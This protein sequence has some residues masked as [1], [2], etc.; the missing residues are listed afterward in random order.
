MANPVHNFG[1][2]A[3]PGRRS[4]PG[5]GVVSIGSG[6][7][8]VTSHPFPRH[9]RHPSGCALPGER[10]LT[11]SERPRERVPDGRAGRYEADPAG[12]DYVR[13]AVDGEVGLMPIQVQLPQVG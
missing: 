4:G 5:T 1:S 6:S 3:Q 11:C 9:V 10:G 12:A 2:P 7:V 13:Q 8:H